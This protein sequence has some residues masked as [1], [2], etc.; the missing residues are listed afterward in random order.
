[1]IKRWP[2]NPRESAARLI[3]YYGPPD[4]TTPSM[5]VWRRTNDGW[6]RTVLS[7]EDVR[8]ALAAKGVVTLVADWT[9]A[10]PAITAA[11]ASFGRNGVPLYVVY[12]RQGEPQVLPQILTPAGF[13]E[14]I[15]GL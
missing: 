5:L 12:P 14:T 6:K 8:A 9:R 2:K 13:I 7:R 4:E 15:A 11:L 1:M 10:D 3:D